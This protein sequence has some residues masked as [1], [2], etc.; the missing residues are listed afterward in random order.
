MLDVGSWI[1]ERVEIQ[2]VTQLKL[3]VTKH[4]G[5]QVRK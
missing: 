5:K 4:V 1:L 3:G 2:I